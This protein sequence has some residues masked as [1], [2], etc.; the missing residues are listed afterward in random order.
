MISK[1]CSTCKQEKPTSE[2]YAQ[3]TN[4]DGLQCI[5]KICHRINA[6]K[7]KKNN[8]ERVDDSDYLYNTSESGFI[9]NT[10]TT[11]F[12]NRRGKIVKITKPEIYEELLLHI[13]RKKLEFVDTDGRLCDYCDQPWT[14]IRRHPNID[15]KEYIKNP[16]NFSIDR[17]DNDVTY[18]KGN[19]IFCHSL[20]NDIKHSV[21]IKMC[22]RI[23][24]LYKMKKENNEME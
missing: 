9:K 13:E 15:K 24:K 20:C 4:K 16:Y 5:C 1:T 8:K 12:T 18:Q 19:I 3:A 10:I 22:E 14:Y 7:W 23:L 11:V 6:A 21:T 17:L 2:F